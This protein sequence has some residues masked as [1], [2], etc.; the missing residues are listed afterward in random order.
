MVQGD[1]RI[2]G[3]VFNYRKDRTPLRLMNLDEGGKV[4]KPLLTVQKN[5]AY[6]NIS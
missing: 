6:E 2:S 5:D 3:S 1:G 4:G